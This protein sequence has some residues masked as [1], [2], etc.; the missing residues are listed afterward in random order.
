MTVAVDLFAGGGFGSLFSGIGLLDLG[1]QRAGLGRP[2]WQVE[3]DPWCR[4][5]LARHWPDA[6]RADD[7]REFTPPAISVPLVAGGF[8]CQPYSVAGAR[9]GNSD[10]RALWP[11]FA[12]VVKVARPAAVIAENVPGLRTLA[13]RGVLA[14]LAAIGFDADWCC[15]RA[16][17]IGAPHQ[18]QRLWIVATHPERLG[19]RLEP[20]WLSRQI[21]AAQEAQHRRDR[22]VVASDA[23][24]V[25]QQGSDR[26]Q[27]RRWATAQ[28][29][30]EDVAAHTNGEGRVQQAIRVATERGWTEHCRWQLDPTPRVDDVGSGGVV[31][32]R[33]GE[34][35]HRRKALGNGVVVA[36]A[37]LVGR[38]LLAQVRPDPHEV[39]Q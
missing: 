26:P 11:H 10:E 12:R 17:D 31:K 3:I 18:R 1:L 16:S 32:P 37:E 14:D 34:L 20:G 2:V 38:A 36:A 39:N 28:Q 27:A 25:G 9:R 22:E 13:L 33:R 15:F 24:G 19:V 35:G 7:V 5:V 21:G 23:A 8:P 30:R 4:R 6:E 29:H